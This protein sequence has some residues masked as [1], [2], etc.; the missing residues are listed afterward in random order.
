MKEQQ[1]QDPTCKDL[2]NWLEG[3]QTLPQR[4]PPAIISSFEVEDGVLYH[5]YEFSDRVYYLQYLQQ[6]ALHF[7]HYP[8]AAANP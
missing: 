1:L 3:R 6:H 4:W 8:P 7:A 2:L 5:L